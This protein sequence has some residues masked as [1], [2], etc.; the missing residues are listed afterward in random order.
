MSLLIIPHKVIFRNR[1]ILL[2]I[3]I[4][5]WFVSCTHSAKEIKT[6][7]PELI[8]QDSLV[9]PTGFSIRPKHCGYIYSDSLEE[10]L[11]YFADV[12]TT[13]QLKVFRSN[14]LLISQISLHEAVKKGGRIDK[15]EL[16]S[17]DTLMLLSSYSNQLYLL[18]KKGVILKEI[19]LGGGSLEDKLLS[20]ELESSSSSPM[21]IGQNSLLLSLYVVPEQE[22]NS[23]KSHEEVF[24]YVK[25]ANWKCPQFMRVDNVYSDSIEFKAGFKMY[26]SL[27]PK[28]STSITF[29]DL[30][31]YSILEDQIAVFSNFSG[32]LSI[33]DPANLELVDSVEIRSS[34]T[35]IGAKLYSDQEAK[36]KDYEEKSN[37]NLQSSGLIQMV[38]YNKYRGH[39]YVLLTKETEAGFYQKNAFRPFILLTYNKRFEKLGEYEFKDN[40]YLPF[41][42]PS[43]K[44]FL[45]QKKNAV[46]NYKKQK[47]IFYEFIY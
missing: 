14:G 46:I 9:F 7:Q 35:S 15:V 22:E 36:A 23:G 41:L 34:Y 18:N 37:L 32:R 12:N 8:M 47:A 4:C 44:G 26:Q 11:Y 27:F 43:E 6:A 13:K 16:V 5:N 25:Q 30:K 31:S 21:S 40:Q 28:D 45:L 38:L 33:I 24:N 3:V 29:Y 1:P 39:H 42:I 20:Y 2:F 10:T 19:N 17:L